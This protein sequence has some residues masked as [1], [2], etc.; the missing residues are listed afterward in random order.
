VFIQQDDVAF[1]ERQK[2]EAAELKA[3]AVKAG[4]K[5]P[6]AGGGI[7]KF[8][9]STPLSDM[10]ILPDPMFCLVIQVR[11]EIVDQYRPIMFSL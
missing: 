1:K 2:R 11:Q 5:G 8:V 3:A 9:R 4:Q 6:L 7:K 10:N